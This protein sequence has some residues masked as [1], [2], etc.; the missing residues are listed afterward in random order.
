M[1][2]LIVK[3]LQALASMIGHKIVH[4]AEAAVNQATEAER[5]GDAVIPAD[6]QVPLEWTANDA[7]NLKA[8]LCSG[9]GTKLRQHMGL[10]VVSHAIPVNLTTNS[11]PATV[12]GMNVMREEVL[13]L[14]EV[15]RFNEAGK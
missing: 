10:F 2:A 7:G 3:L 15:E 11:S 9:T 12:L 13:S 14:A 8:F 6:F 1:Q 5:T 4:A